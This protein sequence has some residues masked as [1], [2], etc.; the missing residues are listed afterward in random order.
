MVRRSAF[1]AVLLAAV[2][3]APATAGQSA[4]V[5]NDRIFLE[6]Y[7]DSSAEDIT[8]RQTAGSDSYT[9]IDSTGILAG[10]GCSQV[11]PT[12]VACAFPTAV[13]N[14]E[15]SGGDDR[16]TVEIA[17]PGRTNP[18]VT[19][20][21]RGGLGNDVLTG[22]AQS[23]VFL[24]TLGYSGSDV[25]ADQ[26]DGKGGYNILD[27]QDSTPRRTNLTVRLPDPGK[28]TVGNGE[29]GENDT[30]TD[31]QAVLGGQGDDRLAGSSEKNVLLGNGGNDYIYA[32]D[33]KTWDH[34]NCGEGPGDRAVVDT[35]EHV[36]SQVGC[37][38]VVKDSAM[39]SELDPPLKA[40]T[41]AIVGATR[42]VTR[43][44]LLKDRY[45]ELPFAAPVAGRL[46]GELFVPITVKPGAR[47]VLAG[48]V[49]TTFA[50]PATSA[51]KVRLSARGRTLLRG[52][53]RGVGAT[54]RLTFAPVKGSTQ[55]R[56]RSFRIR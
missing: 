45:L 51:M 2:A 13:I 9:I 31:V 43:V 32:V 55:V 8:V 30:L 39:S 38:S 54:L 18:P 35:G 20:R 15:A 6:V 11:D 1:T 47:R 14:V 37:E 27:Y 40:L 19:A 25:D 17:E 36:Q 28:S 26:M 48:S 41:A 53:R 24:Q 5:S 29:P 42:R 46:R 22:G 7:G 21:I 34:V 23:D 12:T 33:G 44:K 52:L 49:S 16:V 3:A 56:S 10:T 4:R 50:A